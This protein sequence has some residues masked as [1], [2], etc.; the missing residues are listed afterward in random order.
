[1]QLPNINI[2]RYECLYQLSL[3][4]NAGLNGNKLGIVQENMIVDILEI[5]YLTVSI[6]GKT[7]AG[8][9]CMYMNDTFYVKKT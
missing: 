2:G 4:D 7:K 8:W 5:K 9:I 3:H 1:M 6:W